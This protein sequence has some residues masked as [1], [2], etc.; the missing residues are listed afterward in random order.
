MYESMDNSVR[1]IFSGWNVD[2]NVPVGTLERRAYSLEARAMG[3]Y[4]VP[5]RGG[6]GGVIGLCRCRCYF[7][8]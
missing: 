8:E 2:V 4:D 1:T 7:S 3:G 6:R 5:V